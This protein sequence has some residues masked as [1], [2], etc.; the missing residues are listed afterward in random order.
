[1]KN[2]SFISD[3]GAECVTRRGVQNLSEFQVEEHKTSFQE[4]FG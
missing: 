3:E 4:F 1:M 2:G